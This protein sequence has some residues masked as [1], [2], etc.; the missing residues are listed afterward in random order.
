MVRSMKDAYIPRDG[1]GKYRAD[2]GDARFFST[3]P[4]TWSS[5]VQLN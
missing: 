2:F 5:E 3:S 1:A 4:L